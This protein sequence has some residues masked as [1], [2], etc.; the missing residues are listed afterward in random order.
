MKNYISFILY[1]A[2]YNKLKFTI[3]IVNIL[4]FIWSVYQLIVDFVSSRI[5]ILFSA[6][7]L[8]TFI[9]LIYDSILILI[10]FKNDKSGNYSIHTKRV[11]F[12]EIKPEKEYF[13][14]IY[15]TS[16]N[17][18]EPI[19]WSPRINYFFQ[20]SSEKELIFHFDK[21]KANKVNEFIKTNFKD[22]FYFLKIRYKQSQ[23]DNKDFYNEMK[24]CLSRSIDTTDRI[25]CHG[26]SYYDTVVTN[27]VAGK[28]IMDEKGKTIANYRNFKIFD[29]N[30]KIQSIT[31]SLMNNHIGISTIAI[32]N[33]NYL[34][35]WIQNN[36][37]QESNDLIAPTGSGS[38]DYTDVVGNDFI[39]TLKKA[40]E[41]E[42]LEESFPMK[43]QKDFIKC[44]LITG[45][46]RWITRGAKPEF[47]GIT[48]LNKDLNDLSA[49]TKEVRSNNEFE[50]CSLSYKIDN[51]EHL[52]DILVDV[53]TKKNLS[54]P[55]KFNIET[56]IELIDR[57]P[58]LLNDFLIM[59]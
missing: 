5:Q 41:R 2:K 27:M 21:G 6:I 10:D 14:N 1:T 29:E 37:A 16:N 3:S 22:L 47:V 30:K 4:A 23:S 39:R 8:I 46:F 32:T 13:I 38:C 24:L 35:F 50:E 54:V 12:S 57:K 7:F 28:Y 34:V 33:D 11:N 40:M 20:D 18:E 44:S 15:I 45:Y 36:R 43:H 49:N 48:K 19:T 59:T 26:G 31:T 42:L 17:V 52:K 53:L 56:I 25:Y 58:I 9:K 51:I 55:L